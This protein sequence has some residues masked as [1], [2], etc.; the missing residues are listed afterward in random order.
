MA[1]S[2]SHPPAESAP[3]RS[4]RAGRSPFQEEQRRQTRG[5]ILDA[6]AQVFNARPY[7]SATIDDIVKAARI[8]RVTFYLHFPSKL[9][10]AAD[11][12]ALTKP[13]AC[14]HFAELASLPRHDLARLGQWIVE[15]RGLY[16]DSGYLSVLAVQ[17]KLLEPEG[18]GVIDAMG[19]DL[20]A[21]LAPDFP[22]FAGLDQP[23]ATAA[24]RGVL[25][26][27]LLQRLD[28]FCTEAVL[29][30]QR[31]LDPVGLAIMAEE[32]AAL[33]WGGPAPVV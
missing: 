15:L 25:A 19:E 2:M 13:R 30:P 7:F 29:R 11:L 4:R 31:P 17:I 20:L 27:N 5:R 33:L 1:T 8:S 6:A 14:A 21:V 9:A 26:R 32:M 28:A 24:R 23:G 10:V 12:V 3:G 16:L 22:A 18:Q